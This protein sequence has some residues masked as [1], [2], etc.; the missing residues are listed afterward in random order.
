MGKSI[1]HFLI[2][3][4]FVKLTVCHVKIY[5][6]IYYFICYLFNFYL[7]ICICNVGEI[8]SSI[9]DLFYFYKAY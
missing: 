2:Y 4:A 7:I 9:F 1:L 8:Y 6:G 5:H 3:G